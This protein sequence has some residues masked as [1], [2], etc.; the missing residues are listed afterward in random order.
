MPTAKFWNIHTLGLFKGKI[1]Y[2]ASLMPTFFS[3]YAALLSNS[4]VK[5]L[6]LFRPLLHAGHQIL[7]ILNAVILQLTSWFI[8]FTLYTLTVTINVNLALGLHITSFCSFIRH[9]YAW[10]TFMKA[11]AFAAKGKLACILHWG[12]EYF[13]STSAL[14]AV[15]H[16]F[17]SSSV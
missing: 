9:Q 12:W 1:N 7:T 2:F 11:Y 13:C 14:T 16:I 10:V 6:L 3:W 8:S 4:N 5:V 15:Q 17:L